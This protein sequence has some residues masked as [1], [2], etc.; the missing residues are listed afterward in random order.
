M[1][2]AEFTRQSPANTVPAKKALRA[3]IAGMPIFEEPLFG[4]ASP[5]DPYFASLKHPG[6]YS[7][8]F[9]P[10]REWMPG[11]KTVIAFFLPFTAQVRDS[12]KL[13]MDWPSP[14]WLNARI[15]GQEFTA[16]LTKHIQA[17]LTR[18]GFQ[19]IA[20][21][22]DNRFWSR[23]VIPNEEF[24]LNM[25]FTSNWSERHVAYACGLGTFGLSKGLIT[26]KGVAGRFGSLLTDMEL[27]PTVRPYSFAEEYCTKCGICAKNCPAGAISL[28]NGKD[29]IPCKLFLDQT[30]A[31]QPPYYGCGKCQV[32]VP[33]EKGIPSA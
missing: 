24:P 29:H 1:I 22:W 5:D 9:T 23:S 28:A 12:N 10:P 20:P 8:E 21:S 3:R 31:A 18:E 14:E 32:G 15:E 30:R 6:A 27:P 19:S 17:Y 7:G 13:D 25:T 11:A 16:A 33:C 2:A 26:A 4:Y